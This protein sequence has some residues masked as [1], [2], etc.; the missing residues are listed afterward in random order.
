MYRPG[1]RAQVTTG[2]KVY[3]AGSPI[4]V[5]WTRAPGNNLD[6]IGLYRCRATC[7]GPGA[8]RIY[9]YTDTAVVGT[10]TFGRRNYLGG[11]SVTSLRPGRYVA[12]L[13]LDDGY[14]DIGTSARFRIVRR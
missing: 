4:R 2:R 13:L 9:R 14:H 3:R 1:S 7:P 5:S 10:V 8:Y 6:W 11:G 12:R